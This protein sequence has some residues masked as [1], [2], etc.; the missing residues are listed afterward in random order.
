MLIAQSPRLTLRTWQ[1]ADAP[2]AF[3]FYG[4]SEVAKYIGEGKPAPNVE[5]VEKLLKLFLEH[6]EQN[7]FS[8][9]AIIEN[10]TKKILGICGLHTFNETKEVELGFRILRSEWGRGIA[11]EASQLSLHYAF[12]KLNQT[13]VSALTHPENKATQK[14]LTKL[15]FT[16]QNEAQVKEHKMLRYQITRS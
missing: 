8:P 2:E 4:D 5:H 16:F 12:Q 7:Q 11:T 6:Q 1:L 10:E 14:V 3:H 15:G 9:W 13:T